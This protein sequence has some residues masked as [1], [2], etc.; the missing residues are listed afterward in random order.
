MIYR[1]CEAAVSVF[2]ALAACH[3]L[4]LHHMGGPVLQTPDAILLSQTLVDYRIFLILG[5]TFTYFYLKI[6]GKD[7]SR[8]LIIA[9]TLAWF[10]FFED[11]L[12]MSNVLFVPELFVG[13]L[14]QFSRPVF[15]VAL[16]YMAIES[17]RSLAHA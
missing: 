17:R 9:C 4:L 12:A 13:K 6:A 11:M 8:L 3:V 2:V 16:T 10:S 5:F 7:V 1:I 14:A 15:L